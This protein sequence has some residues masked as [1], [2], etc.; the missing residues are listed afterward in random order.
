MNNK[1]LLVDDEP[2]ILE[3]FR[4]QFRKLYSVDTAESG[5]EGL[6]FVSSKGPYAVVVSDMRMPVMDGIQFLKEVKLLNPETIRVMLTGNADLE[7]A[8]NAVNEGNIF[9]F[10]TKPCPPEWLLKTIQ[11]GIQQYRLVTAE[12]EL[13]EKTLSGSVKVLTEILGLVNPIAFGRSVRIKDYVNHIVTRLNLPFAWQFELAALLSLIGCVTLPPEILGKVYSGIALTDDERRMFEKHPQTARELLVNI[14]RLGTVARMIETQD[15][16]FSRRTE[17]EDYSGEDMV[18]LGG[19]LIKIAMDFENLI[20]SG[21][22]KEIALKEMSA[23]SEEYFNDAV[24]ALNDFE[25]GLTKDIEKT[26]YVKDLSTNMVLNQ[27][28]KTKKDVLIAIKGQEITYTMLQRL[29]SFAKS[30]GINEPF[31]VI[32]RQSDLG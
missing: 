32:E 27:D 24:M 1:V 18:A 25:T 10:L 22:S 3:A 21:K 11:A 8:M 15:Q 9:R 20:L 28:I 29:T 23:H 12:K 17:S 13:L 19:N 16:M 4:R 6:E 26:I 14:P 7:T 5:I 30:V 2:S 31:N